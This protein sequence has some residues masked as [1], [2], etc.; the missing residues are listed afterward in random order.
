MPT[1]DRH[2][3]YRVCEPQFLRLFRASRQF[4]GCVPSRK[5][6]GRGSDVGEPWRSTVHE[7]TSI[8]IT[9]KA[10]TSTSRVVAF[11]LSRFSSVARVK[12]YPFPC[13]VGLNWQKTDENSP[14]DKRAWPS[15]SMRI[16]N[17]S[18]VISETYISI[19][20]IPTAFRFPWMV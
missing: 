5:N 16:L 12:S 13:H 2:V 6:L 14:T 19:E 18:K 9:P 7:R 3:P 15:R 20:K 1:L 17:Y 10:K 11:G 8:T 4:T